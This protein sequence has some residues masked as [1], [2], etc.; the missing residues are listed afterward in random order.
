[1]SARTLRMVWL[2]RRRYAP[3]LELQRQLV[4]QRRAGKNQDT[5]LLLEHEPVITLGRGA[6][7]E[8]VLAPAELLAA[9]GIER[10]AIERGGDVT[11]HAPGQLIAYPII[12][13]AP[14]RRD[15]RRWVNELTEVMRRLAAQNGI[16]AGKHPEHIGLW[17]DA[18]APTRWDGVEHA[19]RPV[20]LG[21][22]GVRISRWVTMHGF[23]L[24]L[25]TDLELFRLIVPCGI[26][27]LGVGSIRS[28]GGNAPSTR[29]AA[30]AAAELFLEQ[31]GA[32]RTETLDLEGVAD[33]A[34]LAALAD[35]RGAE[36]GG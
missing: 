18:D 12:D 23:A 29:A 16:A 24:N 32:K 3:V 14:E 35:D 15:V 25:T 13:L 1:M 8:N 36:G 4:E 5:L 31:L 9:Q 34:L 20:K 27:D 19:S 7:A 26:G 30:D 11:L 6:H 17:A 22:I 28:L 2:G 33:E 21:A 10:I